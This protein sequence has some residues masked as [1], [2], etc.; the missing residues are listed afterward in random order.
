[1]G[2]KWNTNGVAE[3][4]LD[5]NALNSRLRA[6]APIPGETVELSGAVP[7][8]TAQLSG[9]TL[10]VITATQDFRIVSSNSPSLTASSSD[11]FWPYQVPFYHYATTNYTDYVS[12]IPEVGN[13]ID[14]TISVVSEVGI[15]D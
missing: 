10:Y 6:H 4:V 1:M 7:V 13:N 12:L 5:I 14:V 11:L 9:N 2:L 8:I 3:T 15:Q